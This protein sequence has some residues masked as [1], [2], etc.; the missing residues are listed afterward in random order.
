MPSTTTL[1]QHLA[2]LMDS[3]GIG[4]G[5]LATVLGISERTVVRWLADERYPQHESRAK[6]DQLD[7]LVQR[8][9]E[10]F[11][12]PAG[13]ALWLHAPSGYF[14]GLRPVDALLRGRSDAVEAALEAL[15]AGI[16][17]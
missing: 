15:D 7:A 4:R 13:S 5:E 14:G 10:T 3:L 17:V 9:D 12:T 8:L 2:H 1:S 6:L 11:K 16:F